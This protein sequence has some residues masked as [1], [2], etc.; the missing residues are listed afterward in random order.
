MDLG[1]EHP[2]RLL[3]IVCAVL[4]PPATEFVNSKPAYARFWFSLAFVFHFM[5]GRVPRWH[6]TVIASHA[7]AYSVLAFP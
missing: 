1:A 6:G 2:R 4:H 3:H 5:G 7:D